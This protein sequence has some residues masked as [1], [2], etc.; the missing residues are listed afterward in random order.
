[1]CLAVLAKLNELSLFPS[2][3]RFSKSKNK[4]TPTKRVQSG[5]Y[6]FMVYLSS[7]WVLCEILCSCTRWEGSFIYM[8]VHFIV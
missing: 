8:P 6:W 2:L 1:M 4:A 5:V 3:L 7:V